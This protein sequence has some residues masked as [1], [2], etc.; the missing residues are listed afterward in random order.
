MSQPAQTGAAADSQQALRI[1]A[2]W[3][4]Y[5]EGRTQN[6]VAETL[7]LNRVA[8]TRL[9]SEAR[10][11]G[12]VVVHVASPVAAVVELERG[13]ERAF[14]LDEA[15]VAP[16]AAEDG[17]PIPVIAA[18]AGAYVS[19][20]MDN[21]MTVG[22]GWGRTLHASLPYLRGRALT[23]VRAVSLLGGIAQARRFNPAEFAWQFA[24][25]FD[26]EGYLISAPA[27]VDSPETREALLEQCGLDE[28][29]QMAVSSD[30]ALFSAG[31]IEGLRT[32]YRLGH[33]SES[34]RRSLIEAG[35]VG[36]VLYNFID[37]EGAL[38]DHPVN[39]RAVSLDL[40]RLR[41]IPRRVLISGGAEKTA[42]MRGVL[43]SI[44]PTALITDEHTA[45]RLLARE[46]ESKSA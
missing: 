39:R 35:A 8:V 23:G 24:E 9:L 1:K 44:R 30:V 36:D 40:D 2:A 12:E 10:R 13:L 46:P 3:I 37:A 43:R 38:I 27:L 4:Y 26:A 20:L 7:G 21:N 15:V 31:G 25:I 33:V 28:I 18:A 16:L 22:L 14:G 5:I 29:F 45:R 19:G 17:D 6:E 34:E 41:R 11:R 32:S 42:V